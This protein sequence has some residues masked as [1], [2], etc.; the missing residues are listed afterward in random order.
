MQG[1]CSAKAIHKLLIT[2][3]ALSQWSNDDITTVTSMKTVIGMLAVVIVV[4]SSTMRYQ[5][6]CHQFLLPAYTQVTGH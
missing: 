1:H 3:A 6:I 2:L 5:L 4:N